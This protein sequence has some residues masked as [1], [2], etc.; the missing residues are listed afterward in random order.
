MFALFVINKLL[1]IYS[2]PTGIAIIGQFQNIIQISN[3][4]SQGGVNYG[5]TKYTAEYK[6]NFEKVISL[7]STGLKVTLFCSSIMSILLIFFSE[8]I[9]KYFFESS[10]YSYLFIFF[11]VS[12]SFFALNQFLLSILNGLKEIKTLTVINIIQSIYFLCFVSF[13]IIYFEIHG[14]LVGLVTSQS[15]VFIIALFLLRNHFKIKLKNFIS[16]FDK[17]IFLKLLKYS[18]MAIISLIFV[19]SSFLIIRLYIGETLDWDKAGLWQAIILISNSYLLLIGTALNT[20]YLPRLSEINEVRELK[21]ELYDGYKF[22]IPLTISLCFFIFFLK[23]EILLVLFSEQFKSAE[24]LFKWQLIGDFIKV[25]AFLFSYIM[26][27]KAL[28]K[29]YIFTEIIFSISFVLLSIIFINYHGILGTTYAYALN[30]FLYFLV[31][32][33]LIKK[34]IF[35]Y[36]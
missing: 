9:S 5:I 23:E 26:L 24:I 25:C 32:F 4:L 16:K 8:I 14:A 12:I 7:W 33:Y 22:I 28:T 21:K 35:S 31:I 19:P 18:G 27:A 3:G 6:D 15:L 10:E 34:Q 30:S 11:G 13:L 1:A 2:G 17:Q 20:Y 29:T 36:N